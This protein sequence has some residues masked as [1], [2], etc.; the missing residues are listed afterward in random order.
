LKDKEFGNGPL[1]QGN[2]ESG[3]CMLISVPSPIGGVIVLGQ[4]TVT[5]ISGNGLRGYHSIPVSPTIFRAVSYL[6]LFLVSF[7]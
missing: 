6:S 5:Y 7:L 4:E 3:A 2:L 1:F